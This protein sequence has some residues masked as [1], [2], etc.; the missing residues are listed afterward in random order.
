M[1]KIKENKQEIDEIENM[2]ELLE[3]EQS[4]QNYRYVDFQISTIRK[5]IYIQMLGLK[6][7]ENDVSKILLSLEWI[8]KRENLSQSQIRNHLDAKNSE[9]EALFAKYPNFKPKKKFK[10]LF[11]NQNQRQELEGNTPIFN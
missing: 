7:F 10:L 11:L 8:V 2:I 4:V 3:A 1:A 6:E 9:V 5:R